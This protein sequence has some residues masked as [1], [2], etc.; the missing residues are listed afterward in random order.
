MRVISA[1]C[2]GESGTSFG[3][4]GF[5]GTAV[6]NDS[7]VGV[8]LST[9]L[10]GGNSGAVVSVKVSTRRGFSLLLSTRKPPGDATGDDTVWVERSSLGEANTSLGW[11]WLC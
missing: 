1:V 3:C 2:A 9:S 8:C 4:P 10:G 7:S 6:D 5:G 11:C